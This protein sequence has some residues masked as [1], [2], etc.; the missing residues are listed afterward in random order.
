MLLVWG[1]AVK[2]GAEPVFPE[3]TGGTEQEVMDSE[4]PQPK[5]GGW[6]W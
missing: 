1:R 4:K 3:G 2:R 5:R 6:W